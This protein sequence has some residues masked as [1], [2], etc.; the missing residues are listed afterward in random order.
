[1]LVSYE[2]SIHYLNI[3]FGDAWLQSF[4]VLTHM[5]CVTRTLDALLLISISFCITT[6]LCHPQ[7]K[8]KDIDRVLEGALSRDLLSVS[9]GLIELSGHL[10]KG[11]L[12]MV[13]I[14]TTALF[15]DTVVAPLLLHTR[16]HP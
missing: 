14:D 13:H 11:C 10:C 1:M 2:L 16:A 12:D 3:L 5:E 9:T 8:L 4:L 15:F 7:A 6:C